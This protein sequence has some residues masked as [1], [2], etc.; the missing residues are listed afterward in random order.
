MLEV[1]TSIQKKLNHF[2]IEDISKSSKKPMGIKEKNQPRKDKKDKKL[3]N[4]T[5]KK[6]N[7]DHC[8]LAGI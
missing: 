3:V 4:M 7:C 8:N 6:K 1:S 5:L 2:K